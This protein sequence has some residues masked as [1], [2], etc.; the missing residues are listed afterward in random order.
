[1]GNPEIGR[2]LEIIPGLVSCNENLKE[3]FELER[4]IL[5]VQQKIEA[6]PSRGALPDA[7]NPE[8]ISRLQEKSLHIKKPINSLVDPSTFDSHALSMPFEE[9]VSIL[10]ARRVGSL[11]T[12][13]L[14]FSM[15]SHG[16]SL[17]KLIDAVLKE[18]EPL[19]VEYGAWLRV[20]PSL[21]VYAVSSVLRPFFEEVARRVDSSYYEMW[22]ERLCP[23][24]GR[25]PALG[26]MRDRKRYLFCTFCGAEYPSDIA[27]CVH[28]GNKD[29]SSL[30]FLSSDRDPKNRVDFCTKC[31]GYLKVLDETTNDLVPKDLLDIL[32][33]GLDQAA[34]SKG[35]RRN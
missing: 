8:S 33:L 32:T 25:T 23:I 28:C 17:E 6:S 12:A 30:K 15:S 16:I 24:C 9:I 4:D 21:L 10:A 13:K 35:L 14:P 19:L 22:W 31:N 26:I 34:A 20:E 3:P 27:L 7:L 5:R 18:D 29:P 11:E 2:R 1:M